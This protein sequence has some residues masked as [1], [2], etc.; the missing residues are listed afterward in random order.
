MIVPVGLGLGAVLLVS[1]ILVFLSSRP[2]VTAPEGQWSGTVTRLWRAGGGDIGLEVCGKE[3]KNCQTARLNANVAAPSR[4]Q[5][6]D[7][8]RASVGFGENVGLVL[9]RNTQVLV[10]EANRRQIKMLRGNAVVDNRG[11]PDSS[12]EVQVP[13]GTLNVG[14]A[15]VAI[16]T[17]SMGTVVDVAHGVLKVVDDK[18]HESK[19]HAGEQL[20]IKEGQIQASGSNANLGEDLAWS[21]EDLS[22]SDGLD[23][24]SRGLGELKAKKPGA[25]DELRGAVSLASHK[26]Q[27]RVVANLVRTEIDETFVN[28]SNDVLEGI[29]RFPLPADAKIE[30]LALDVDGKMEEGAFVDRDRA[31]AIWRGAIVNATPVNQRVLKDDIVWV[32]GPWRDPALLEWQRGGRFEL[33]IYPIPKRGSRRVV[34]TYTQVSNPSGDARRYTYPLAYDPSG[35]TKIGQ[36]DLDVQVRGHDAAYGVRSIGYTLRQAT[37]GGV[38]RL[39]LSENNFTPHGDI[40]LEYALP[41]R[42]AELKAWAYTVRGDRAP[43]TTHVPSEPQKIAETTGYAAL[44]LRPAWPRNDSDLPRDMIVVV[45]ASRSMLGEN[46]KRAQRLALRLLFELDPSDHASVMT[47]DTACEVLPEGMTAAGNDLTQS[48]TRFLGATHVEGASDP[49]AAVHAA[50]A[51]AG[52][53]RSERPLSIVYIGDGTPTVGPVRPG[54]IEKAIDRD[55]GD[56]AASVIAVGV[57]NESD[58]ET[59]AAIARGGGGVTVNYLPGKSLDEVAYNVIG[60]VRGM[61]LRNVRVTLPEGLVDAAPRRPDSL[62][63]GGE[64][65]VL[66]RMQRP[67][68]RGDVVLRGRLGNAPFERRWPINLAATESDGNAFVPRL[69]AAARITDIERLGD[70]DAKREVIELSQ[71]HHV[72]SRYTSLLVLESEAMLKAFHLARTEETHDWSGESDDEQQV[73]LDQ[74]KGEQSQPSSGSGS[75]SMAA[76]GQARAKKASGADFEDSIG[77]AQLATKSAAIDK[78]PVARAAAPAPAAAAATLAKAERSGVLR[79]EE[80]ANPFAVPPPTTGPLVVQPP[81]N[82]LLIAE[83]EWRQR[84][85]I[86]MRR[87]WVRKGSFTNDRLPRDANLRSLTKAED[88]FDKE[89]ERRNGLKSLLALYTRRSELDHADSLVERWIDKEP[90]DPD[91]LTARA[92]SSAR[93][94]MRSDAIRMLGSVV[95]ARPDDV[96][97]QQRLAR[98]YDWSGAR[99]QS[100]RF[101]VALAEIHADKAEW[102]AQAVRCNRNLDSTWLADDLL[103]NAAEKVRSDAE[104]ILSQTPDSSGT[105]SGD[106][107]IEANWSADADVDI[108]LITPEG[109]RVSWLGAP[110]R[111]V[112][113]AR[114]VTSRSGE[115]LAVRNAPAGNYLIE[116][117]RVSG[118]GSVRGDLQLTIADLKKNVPFSLSGDRT[119]VGIAGITVV[120]KLV[121]L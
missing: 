28:S 30:R 44:T 84:R 73:D 116:L 64:L 111:Q 8:T 36:F 72:A 95:D 105:L 120:Q 38:T 11:A 66:A 91:A 47:C 118:S 75:A 94:G 70:A 19:V 104:R 67:S 89:P 2:K 65:W 15:K 85:M 80:S 43:A 12:L 93:R 27:V 10:P 63:S 13:G 113:T 87:T 49:T 35:T 33:R 32:P 54:T 88:D 79:A 21:D 78:R 117:V 71:T 56:A 5:T 59:L 97:A 45:D 23:E 31:A 96:K 24:P 40:I 107:R 1:G 58:S 4:I 25:N 22:K 53:G 60:A 3:G 83:P 57:G 41:N 34:M 46:F 77:A 42:D 9:D 7:R 39:S 61:H 74:A 48:A 68:I 98:L 86:P 112:I 14:A 26:V 90:L 51:L 121:A 102:L 100:C 50:L 81:N 99:E 115:S 52:R 110:T 6:D 76:P 20:R 82:Q 92:D 17:D 29:Y 16:T 37:D 69:F 55:L 108:A 114:D 101:W 103:G 62:R 18:K 106:L 119:V 109:Q